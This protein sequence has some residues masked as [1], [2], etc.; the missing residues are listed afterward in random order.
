MVCTYSFLTKNDNKSVIINRAKLD[1]QMG[2]VDYE[3]GY[4]SRKKK[5]R[6]LHQRLKDTKRSQEIY[7]KIMGSADSTSD[8]QSLDD[9][10]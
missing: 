9:E 10:D 6:M 1:R 4:L 2:D 7:H 8:D 3:K 5:L